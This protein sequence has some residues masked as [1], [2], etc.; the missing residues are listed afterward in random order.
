[1]TINVYA[2]TLSEDQ[3]DYLINRVNREFGE[4]I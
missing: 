1:M 3:V 2:Q 4:A